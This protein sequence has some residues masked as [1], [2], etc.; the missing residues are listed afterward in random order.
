MVSQAVLLC[1]LCTAIGS[2]LHTSEPSGPVD[3]SPEQASEQFAQAQQRAA[4]KE[5]QARIEEEHAMRKL[6]TAKIEVHKETLAV[7]DSAAEEKLLLQRAGRLEQLQRD[8]TARI[9][10]R[11]QQLT[12]ARE[13]VGEKL[14]VQRAVD[15]TVSRTASALQAAEQ[16]MHT[17]DSLVLR[18]KAR[19]KAKQANVHAARD[20]LSA[21]HSELRPLR[22][23]AGL[24][25]AHLDAAEHALEQGRAQD[26]KLQLARARQAEAL[27]QARVNQVRLDNKLHKE[28]AE[29]VEQMTRAKQANLVQQARVRLLK[30]AEHAAEAADEQAKSTG[31]QAAVAKGIVQQAEAAATLLGGEDA[32]LGGVAEQLRHY[33]SLVA[34][35]QANVTEQQRDLRIAKKERAMIDEQSIS[36]EHAKA[37]QAQSVAAEQRTVLVDEAKAAQANQALQKG[38]LSSDL[39][40]RAEESA[41]NTYMRAKSKA[42]TA[43]T[44]RKMAEDWMH[45][46][47]QVKIPAGADIAQAQRVLRSTQ[48]SIQRAKDALHSAITAEHAALETAKLAR[49]TAQQQH[50][51]A[52]AGI[53]AVTLEHQKATA[54]AAAA[55]A[56]EET[57]TNMQREQ[58]DLPDDMAVLQRR[59]TR[60]SQETDFVAAQLDRT[61]TRLAAAQSKVTQLQ[62]AQD[63]LV[64]M[65]DQQAKH[66]APKQLFAPAP[67]HATAASGLS[68][69]K[70]QAMAQDA[71]RASTE[72]AES[73]L[74]LENEQKK[75]QTPDSNGDPTTILT[76]EELQKQQQE[77]KAVQQAGLEEQQEKAALAVEE[78]QRRV[79]QAKVQEATAAEE[80]RKAAA[81]QK[82]SQEAALQAERENAA[83]LAALG[84]K[85]PARS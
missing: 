32:K 66:D 41:M 74:K 79:E 85:P 24:S 18:A 34:R 8:L 61:N 42:D 37:E 69:Q 21:S 12:D 65:M 64:N 62:A 39:A 28:K 30:E 63:S 5:E 77:Q 17:Q 72:G 43:K 56:A 38:Q 13:K 10:A 33:K 59:A 25:T 57:L 68:E 7:H 11:A 29:A 47:A 22:A 26:H 84:V 81:E 15:K 19:L 60:V 52:Q 31:A 4:Q 75:L 67:G 9:E 16:Q 2:A 83:A 80:A 76:P 78:E 46:A 1:L 6:R 48:S 36:A 27:K 53:A 70:K 54:T 71:E 14:E 49:G 20:A 51:R 45:N 73:K 50:A 3:L 35:L 44:H 23:A 82:E 58:G 40:V 55:S